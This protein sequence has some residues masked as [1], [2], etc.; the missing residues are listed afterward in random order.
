[1]VCCAGPPFGAQTASCID[2]DFKNRW[3]TLLSVD[4]LVA[5]VVELVDEEL[6]LADNTCAL[7][8]NCH[9]QYVTVERLTTAFCNNAHR[10]HL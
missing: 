3:R 2:E 8:L 5:A 1:M 4:D 6:Q 10:L 9:L 7:P